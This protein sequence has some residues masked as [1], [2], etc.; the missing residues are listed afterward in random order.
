MLVLE[1]KHREYGESN[2]DTWELCFDNET[3][4]FFVRHC[5]TYTDARFPLGGE[6]YPVEICNE[7]IYQKLAEVGFKKESECGT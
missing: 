3:S 1:L 4:E 7:L 2:K 6:R 5:T